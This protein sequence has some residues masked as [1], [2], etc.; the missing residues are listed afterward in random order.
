MRQFHRRGLLART[1]FGALVL[2]AALSPARAQ[3]ASPF[4]DGPGREI[5]AVACTQCHSPAPIVQ[6]RMNDVGWRRQVFNMVLRGAQ[7]GPA[8]IDTVATYLST[9]FGPGVAFPN[10]PKV[11][12]KLADG[13]GANVVEGS[14]SLCHGLDRVVATKR[15]AHQWDAI[16]HRMIAVGAPV[17]DDQAKDAASYLA[18]HY[19]A[20]MQAAAK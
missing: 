11:D 8:D 18:A 6:L 5:V 7:I 10:T 12:V 16:I 1:A 17:S 3:Q 9:A 19:G 20:E 15:S 13:T 2:G 4:P 14:C